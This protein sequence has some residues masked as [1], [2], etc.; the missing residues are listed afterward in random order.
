MKAWPCEYLDAKL[1]DAFMVVNTKLLNELI[2][3]SG[4]NMSFVCKADTDVGYAQVN[5]DR[6]EVTG[7]CACEFQPN[8]MLG[9]RLRGARL[10]RDKI[11]KA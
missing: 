6:V 9:C 8:I 3:T 1:G 10:L 11:K 7:L 4:S 5:K 2:N